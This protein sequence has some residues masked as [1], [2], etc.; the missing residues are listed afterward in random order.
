MDGFTTD[1]KFL[2]AGYITLSHPCLSFHRQP[3]K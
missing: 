3:K 1:D 2:Q